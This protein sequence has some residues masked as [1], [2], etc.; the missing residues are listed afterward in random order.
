[1]AKTIKV[2]ENTKTVTASADVI[3]TVTEKSLTEK[4]FLEKI[5]HIQAE[6]GFGTHLNALIKERIKTL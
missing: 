6:G 2:D 5:L 1:M 3:V 4:Q